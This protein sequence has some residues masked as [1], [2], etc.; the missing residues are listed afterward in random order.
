MVNSKANM[1]RPVFGLAGNFVLGDG[2]LTGVVS[3]A[4]GDGYGLAKIEGSLVVLGPQGRVSCELPAPEGAALFALAARSPEA[5]AYFPQASQMVRLRGCTVAPEYFDPPPVWGEILSIAMPQSGQ[6]AMVVKR[7]T[8][9]WL[10]RAV[11]STGLILREVPLLAVAEPLYLSR[12]GT[13]VF[14]RDGEL[15]VRAP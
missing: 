12:D 7:D 2:L 15:I 5:L 4:F 14:A 11:L 1:L 13:L 10:L 8:T 6:V 9:Y 3:A